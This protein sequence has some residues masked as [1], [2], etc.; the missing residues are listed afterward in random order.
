[1]VP[2]ER[3]R[4]CRD[5]LVALGHPVEW[6]TWPMEH[7]VCAEEIELIGAWLIS[8]CAYS[9]FATASSSVAK[10]SIDRAA[11]VA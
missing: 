4:E 5:A 6:R 2:E 11:V 8:R 9:P 1:M 10:V 3:G 7:H